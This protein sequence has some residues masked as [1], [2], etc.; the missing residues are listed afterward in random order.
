MK[1]FLLFVFLIIL[2]AMTISTC[3]KGKND[4]EKIP[5]LPISIDNVSYIGLYGNSSSREATQQEIIQIVDWL[6]SIKEYDS[7]IDIP[8][9]S[10]GRP[11]PSSIRVFLKDTAYSKSPY[12][13]E[14]DNDAIIICI[15]ET[16]KGYVVNQ[17]EL[18]HLL[19]ELRK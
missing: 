17:P 14:R 2:V 15:P 1:R 18:D 5:Y 11:V 19:K 13:L 16:K 4:K 3:D 8:Q 7:K 12:I 6:N 10:N 9:N